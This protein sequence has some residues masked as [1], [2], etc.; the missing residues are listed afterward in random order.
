MTIY[1]GSNPWPEV[2]EAMTAASTSFV[3]VID[4]NRK[5]GD[6]IAEITG[7]EAGMVTSGSAGGLVM[8]MA[9]C[10]T[11][12]SIPNVRRLPNTNGMKSELVIQ[13]IHR[14]GFSA[15]YTHTGASFVEV[16]NVNSTLPE[17][18][19]D[20]ITENT[21]AVAFLFA[22]RILTN[23]LTLPQVA[24]IAHAKGVPVI[25]DAAGRLPPKENLT[26]YIS[27]GADLVV[28]S[29]GKHI[30]GPQGTG[31]LFGRRDL[32]EAARMNSAPN[33]A[34]G[35]SHKISK[36]EM[37]GLYTALQLLVE[38]DDETELEEFRGL[39]APIYD[40]L[41]KIPSLQV[42]IEM[43]ENT[44]RLPTLVIS[45]IGENGKRDPE[46]M[47][48]ELIDG[49]P[50]VFLLYD[51]NLSVFFVNPFNLQADEVDILA[52]RLAE[53]LA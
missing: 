53:V 40:R 25:V 20:A 15:L 24:E 5:V 7:A 39:L 16:G 27:E 17:E 36:E 43:D 31:M 49:Y 3:N 38:R 10:M 22:P 44:Y 37:V 14:G 28:M 42:S 35:R 6:F 19:D 48:K 23:G 34:I 8:S 29:G 47:Q 9:A 41:K 33:P 1:G 11:G 32:I 46:N 52:T 21:A 18:L 45:L 26:R 30:R 4:L 51:T 2:M 12:T 13:K 50:S